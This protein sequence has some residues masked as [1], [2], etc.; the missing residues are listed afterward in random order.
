[1]ANEAQTRLRR[2]RKLK[3]TYG[4]GLAGQKLDL[5]RLLDTRRLPRAKDV[6]ALHEILCLLRA[7]PDNRSVLAQVERMLSGFAD[8]SD[9]QRHAKALVDSGIAGTRIDYAFYWFTASWLARRWPDQISIDWEAFER[10]PQLEKVLHILTLYPESLALEELAYSVQEWIEQLKGPDETGATFL[11]RRYEALRLDPFIRETL[12]EDPDVPLRIEPGPG[13]PSRTHAKYAK[14]PVV[15]QTKPLMRGRP[16]LAAELRRPPL[17]VRLVSP[18]EG[19]TL[20]H[21]AREAMVTRS[22]DLDA[23]MHADKNDVRI[24][25]CGSGLQFIGYGAVPERRLMLESVYGFLTLRNGVP[26]GY[27]L[28]SPL[29]NSVAVS[30]NVFETF[31]GAESARIYGRVLGMVHALFDADT[32]SVDPYQLGHDNMEGLKSGAWWFYYKLGF[33]P[34]DRDVRRLMRAELRR[35]KANPGHRSSI[36]ALQKLSAADVFFYLGRPRDDVIGKINLGQIGL[37]VVRYL[38]QR[39]GADREAATRVCSREAAALLGLRSLRGF[40]RGERLA[41]K[42][43]SPLILTLPNVSRWSRV[44]RRALVS[45]VRAKGGRRESDFVR[46]FDR[47]RPLRRAVLK[48]A[49]ED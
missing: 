39:F 8:R 48:L 10:Q 45:V 6:L 31:R 5:L 20:I 47:H 13:T 41:W 25:D 29:F 46:L 40:S 14:A 3:D 23:F 36:A 15:F 35:I 9:L 4:T 7:Y 12:F 1:M 43:W 21:L 26:L 17:A 34:S 44:N 38:G 32:L 33:R 27:V 30:Y 22:R 16:D 24:V 28:A 42:R 49:E 18:R 2:L 11:I 19:Q 37:K